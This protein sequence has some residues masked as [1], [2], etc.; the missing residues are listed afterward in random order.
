MALH[1]PTLLVV[2]VFIFFLMSLLTFHAWL[3]ETRERPL[4]YLGGMM[5]LAAV[6]MVLVSLRDQGADYVPKVL[7][8]MTLLL[9][10]AFNW[11]AMRVFAGRSPYLPGMLAGA[12]VWLGLCLVPSF[13]Q[14]MTVRVSVYSLLVVSYGLLTMLE[15]WRSRRHLEVAYLPALALT[16]LHTG[17]YSMRAVID[18]GLALDQALQGYGAGVPFFPFMLFESMLYVIGIAYVTLSMVK[19]QVELRLKAAAYCDALTGIGNRRA[20][21]AK[22][23]RMLIE[24]RRRGESVALLLCDLD[25]FKRLNDAFGHQTGDQALIAFSQ[26]LTQTLRKQDVFARIGGEEFACL[27]ATADEQTAVQVAERIRGGFA[28]LPLLAPGLLSVSIGVVSSQTAGY[29]LSRLLSQAD[30]ALYGAKDQGRNRVQT[31][32]RELPEQQLS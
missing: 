30:E 16:L 23:E 12:T 18:Q 17:F 24:C 7:G 2:S 8:N 28:H 29:E 13:Y 3:R 21:M 31:V 1:I 10:A 9:S 25:H 4:A 6:G 19:E 5:L 32:R 26:V 22:G 11:T 20:F 27:L 15:F 14:S